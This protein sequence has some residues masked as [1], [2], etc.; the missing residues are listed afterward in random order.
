MS[1]RQPVQPKRQLDP[2]FTPPIGAEDSFE[3]DTKRVIVIPDQTQSLGVPGVTGS[4]AIDTGDES[5]FALETP[6]AIYVYDQKLRRA[7]GGQQVVDVTL[8]VEEIIGAV[9]YEVQI[10]KV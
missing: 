8:D 2:L 4:P 5:T 10:A 1:K 7:P 9:E 6:D 3:V